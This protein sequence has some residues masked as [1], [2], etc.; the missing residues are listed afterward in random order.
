M[1]HRA[2]WVVPVLLPRIRDGAVLVGDGRILA[3]DGYSSLKKEIPP[4]TVVL[5]HGN[6]AIMPALINAHTHLELSALRGKISFPRAGFPDWLDAM[7]SQ[8]A[9]L[10]VSGMREGFSA[11]IRELREDGTV[12][13]GD[14]TN[15]AYDF[16][17][18][19][20]GE[21]MSGHV[22]GA[23]DSSGAFPRRLVFLELLGFNCES[24]TAAFPD[25][26]DPAMNGRRFTAVPH[27]PYSVSSQVIAEA[28]AECRK[29]G[30]PF[31]IH[32][33]EH[34][35][36]VE[37]L[38]SGTGFVREFL[39][40][41]GKWVPGWRPPSMS[42]VEYLDSLGSLDSL[43]LLVH[44]VHLSDSDWSIVAGRK[45]SVCF[46]PRS[47]RNLGAGS[48][49]IPR[50]LS[51][52][53]RSCLG[54]D[55]LASNSDLNLFSE[56][57][58]VLDNYPGINPDSVLAMITANPAGALGCATEFGSI[59]PGLEAALL[60][61]SLESKGPNLAEAIIH[62]GQKGSWKWANRILEG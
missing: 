60:V 53:I 14:I 41:L 44:A 16:F 25:R 11:A 15:G 10:D 38:R 21:S 34:L 18:G 62:S 4:D 13:C 33:A 37:F 40:R 5:D 1:L 56:A 17:L 8:R 43:T 26:I 49:D 59:G 52:G 7:S 35:E 23:A 48:P 36:E 28:K 50:A 2:E 12:L 46:C 39:D 20:D 58:F 30:L 9:D 57:G 6:S 27:S 51:S 3:V 42:P 54:T 19:T 22:L 32:A 24:L 29:L 31:S 47:N 45:C 55:S 61:V